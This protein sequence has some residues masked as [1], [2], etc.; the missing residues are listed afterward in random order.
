MDLRSLGNTFE[1]LSHVQVLKVHCKDGKGI[2]MSKVCNYLNRNERILSERKNLHEY[3]D[4][5]AERAFRGKCVAQR[6]LSEAE[7][8]MDRR[9]W[10]RRNS[11]IALYETNPQL[12]SQILELYIKQINKQ[13]KHKNR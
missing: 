10:E 8:E 2:E 4:N 3:L 6:R 13:I 12:E 5:E 7:V 9:S 1:V 11:D